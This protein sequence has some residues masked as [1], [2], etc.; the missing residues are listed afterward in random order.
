LR[1]TCPANILLDLIQIYLSCLHV[2]MFCT[3]VSIQ[4]QVASEKRAI[5]KIIQHYIYRLTKILS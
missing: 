1:A 3:V 5:I 4:V 2:V